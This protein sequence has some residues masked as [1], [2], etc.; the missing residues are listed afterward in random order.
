MSTWI[1]PFDETTINQHFGLNAS[2]EHGNQRG[3]DATAQV[4]R[5]GG[6]EGVLERQD[7]G[8]IGG[9]A[10]SREHR[11]RREV[12]QTATEAPQL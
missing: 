2:Y 10:E 9:V 1:F 5:D 3:G 6:M 4:D 7:Q 11:S 12:P 8:C